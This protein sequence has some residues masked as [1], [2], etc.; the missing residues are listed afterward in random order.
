MSDDTEVKPLD[1]KQAKGLANVLSEPDGYFRCP[2]AWRA[3]DAIA[4]GRHRVIDTA[5]HT[6]I[7]HEE[8]ERLRAVEGAARHYFKHWLQDEAADDGPEFTGCSEEQHADAKRLSIALDAAQ[9]E[10]GDD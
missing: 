4:D 9:Q 8:L 5:T 6:D 7:R 3:L 1:V 2:S 10:E